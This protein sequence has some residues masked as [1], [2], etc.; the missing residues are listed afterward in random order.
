[1]RNIKIVIG[2]NFGDEGKGLMTDYF[3]HQAEQRNEK[4]IV[5]LHNG[6]AQRGH[7]VTTPTG[8]KHVFHHFGSGTF[9]EADTYCSKDFIL[10]PMI[11]SQEFEELKA[12]GYEPKVYIHPLCKI[13]TPFDMILNQIIEEHRSGNR[14][15]SCGMGIYETLLR[16]KE[17]KCSISFGELFFLTDEQIREHLYII[18]DKWMKTRFRMEDIEFI[19]EE[20]AN[21]INS[22][23]LI[24]HYL[25]D[26]KFMREVSIKINDSILSGYENIVF[27]NGQGLLLDQ[28][29]TEY[30]P[31]LTP[32]NTGCKNALDIISKSFSDKRN[33]RIEVCYVTRTYLTRHGAGRLDNE[34]KREDINNDMFDHTNLPN[35][36]QGTL[37]Y[38][39]IFTES[40]MQRILKDFQLL[41]NQYLFVS[42]CSLAI[43]HIDEYITDY[44]WNLNYEFET[45][46]VSDGET[47]NNIRAREHLNDFS[48]EKIRYEF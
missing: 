16:A 14:H 47:Y 41:T 1:M 9:C 30:F 28:N 4:C 15:G 25:M 11:F 24:D 5:V 27:E 35:P 12:L 26:L 7:T 8:I 38:G 21:I 36:H 18:R 23:S 48:K 44:I 3:C 20:W 19:S 17:N 42:K 34:C 46:Y 13:S 31:H 2:A 6:G 32:S 45:T 39:F 29:N 37:R 33:L 40:L 22:S 10:N 43:T